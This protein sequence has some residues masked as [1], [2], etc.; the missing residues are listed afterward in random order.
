MFTYIGEASID[1]ADNIIQAKLGRLKVETPYAN[2]DDIRMAPNTFEGAWLSVEYTDAFKTQLFYFKNWAGYDSQDEDS[3]SSQNEFKSLVS[4]DSFGM[5]GGSFIYEY[6]K[7]SELSLWY[8]YIDDMA[9]IVYAEMIG[10]YFTDI[11]N[12][13]LDYGLQASH[14]EELEN[15]GV[16]GN[17]FGALAILHY[18]GFFL[19]GAYNISL[20]DAG[21][22]VS[23]GF[24]GGPYYTS[25]DEA[26]ISA[27][28]EAYAEYQNL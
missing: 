4:D 6:A 22:S 1:Y 5:L 25:L 14:I 9:T 11:E 12:L 17:V 20:S 21:K 23:N 19:G 27:V 13:H 18:N 3:N 15:S 28:S 7:N 24:G 26:S 8:N 16:D 2:S 10:I